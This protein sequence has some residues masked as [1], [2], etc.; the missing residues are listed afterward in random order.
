MIETKRSGSGRQGLGVR[1]LA[2][3]RLFV[4]IGTLVVIAALI[5]G[6][7]IVTWLYNRPNTN[8]L[9][10]VVP[11][12]QAIVQQVTGV[13]QSTV[14][15]VGTGGLP[16]PLKRI[17]GQPVLLGPHGH[18]EFF[19]AGAEFCQYCATERWAILNALGRFGSFSH[20]GQMQS[21]EENISTFSFYQ[22]TYSSQ[23]V[24]FVPVEALGNALDRD[25][26]HFVKLQILTAQQQ[27]I[28]TTY[29]GP[30]YFQ[31]AGSFPFIDLGNSYLIQE[32]G[33]DPG[34]LQGHSR[35][36]TLSWQAIANALSDP[37]SPITKA[38]IG[39][40]NYLTAALCALTRQPPASVCHLPAILQIE[41]SID[42][43][44][45]SANADGGSQ[46]W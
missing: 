14:Q 12:N 26:Q 15:A 32:S 9:L 38:I 16:D 20:L 19:F 17:Q 31:A 30:P 5:G 8:P 33:F 35:Q 42:K 10:K 43:P 4:I 28:F 46:P 13:R 7:F 18:P 6:Y 1:Q 41:Q 2:H 22:S 45:S 36:S 21:Y 44:A 24:D 34:I 3:R 25:G 11:A 37:A 23:Y 40:A 39:T 29:N 27:Q